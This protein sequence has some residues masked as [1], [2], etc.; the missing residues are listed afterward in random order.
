MNSEMSISKNALLDLLGSATAYYP[1]FS[2]VLGDPCA[3]I[4]VSR[5]F[6]WTNKGKDPDGWIRKTQEEIEGETGLTLRNQQT[7]RRKAREMGVLEEALKGVPAKMHYR[8]NLDKLAEL[9]NEG[10]RKQ[11]RPTEAATQRLHDHRSSLSDLDKPVCAS[12]SLSDLD[13]P[14]CLNQTNKS[15][16]IRQTSL[17]ESDKPLYTMVTTIDTTMVTTGGET[18]AQDHPVDPATLSPSPSTSPS[19]AVIMPALAAPTEPAIELIPIQVSSPTPPVAAPLPTPLRQ[20]Q[21]PAPTIGVVTTGDPLV[22]Q[23]VARG[24]GEWNRRDKRHLDDLVKQ[25]TGLGMTM[26][27]FRAMVD[28]FLDKYG[29]REMAAMDTDLASKTLAKAQDAVLSLCGIDARFRSVAGLEAVFVSWREN[30]YRGATLPDGG[31][32]VE[33]AGKMKAGAI[34]SNLKGQTPHASQAQH[35][36]PISGGRPEQPAYSA[37]PAATDFSRY[38]R[39]RANRQ[40]TTGA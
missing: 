25:V 23:A 36:N 16:A 1:A 5:I 22:D 15:D 14:V 8:V 40:P 39:N 27:D 17:A 10:Y 11:W 2:K 29:R 4:F 12:P 35:R 28:A 3:G 18:S 38:N 13:E 6:Y 9:L 34:Q 7:A 30:D 33:H 32:L 24:K 26:T 31:Q 37:G 19:A 21:G 20:A